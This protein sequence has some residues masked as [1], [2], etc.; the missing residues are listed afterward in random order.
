MRKWAARHDRE[1]N[2]ARRAAPGP[3][4]TLTRKRRKEHAR[5]AESLLLW[6]ETPETAFTASTACRQLNREGFRPWAVGKFVRRSPLFVT[7]NLDVSLPKEFQATS[8]RLSSE[9]R[10]AWRRLAAKRSQLKRG[11]SRKVRQEIAPADPRDEGQAVD[12]APKNTPKNTKPQSLAGFWRSSDN[13]KS[14]R[15]LLATMAGDGWVNAD[16]LYPA[17]RD[18]FGWGEAVSKGMISSAFGMLA[19]MGGLQRRRSGRTWEYSIG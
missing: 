10:A 16:D 11:G 13:V 1:M 7:T 18:R 3:G 8:F 12:P 14:L 9:G 5:I 6:L 17:V 2:A 15:K 19:V 4:E